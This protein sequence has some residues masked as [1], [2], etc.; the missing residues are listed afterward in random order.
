MDVAPIQRDEQ[1]FEWYCLMSGTGS[2]HGDLVGVRIPTS[3]GEIVAVVTGDAV[4]AVVR[5]DVAEPEDRIEEAEWRGLP[6]ASRRTG[7]TDAV[8]KE[9]LAYMSGQRRIFD[10]PLSP[11]GGGE[12]DR[13]VWRSLAQLAPFGTTATYGE[14][15]K[16]LGRPGAAR[17]VGHANALNPISLIVPCH[18]II[19]SNGKL[20]GYGGGLGTVTKR[21]LLELEARYREP[22]P[23]RLF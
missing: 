14:V 19:G 10:L 9:I 2:E 11:R 17:A 7:G 12:F 4:G 21:A 20:V 15:A 22:D 18:R 16:R 6:V 1:G 13:E 8:T 5:I 23:D 3:V